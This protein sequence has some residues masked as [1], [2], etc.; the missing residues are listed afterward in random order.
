MQLIQISSAACAA[1]GTVRACAAALIAAVIALPMPAVA[2]NILDLPA[3]LQ[4]KFN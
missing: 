4:E 2:S 3:Q 1:A